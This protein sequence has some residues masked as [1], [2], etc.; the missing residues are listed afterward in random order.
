MAQ[1]RY[2]SGLDAEQRSKLEQKLLARQTGRCFICDDAIDLMLH[3]GQL[4][5]D[6]IDPLI[7]DGLDAENN[8][9]LTHASCN[10]SKG[11]ANLEI[12][13]RLAEFER[14]QDAAQEAGKRGANLG[15][16]LARYG[17]AKAVLRIRREAAHVEFSL[18]KVGDNSIRRVPVYHDTLSGMDSFFTALPLEYLHHDDRINPRSIGTNIRGLIEEFIR[19]RPQLHV[20]LAWWMPEEDGGGAVKVFDGQHK[21]AAQILLGTR[22]LPVRVFLEPDVNVLLLA[23]T[24]AGGRLRQVAFDSAVMRHLGSSL[25][26]ERVN[27]YKGM[28][29]LSEN[30]Y[31]FS[32]QD[33]VRFFRGERREMERYIIDAQRDAITHDPQNTLLEFVEWAGKGA[34]RPL[35]YTS[36][37]GSV[38]RVFLYKKALDTPIDLGMEEGTNPRQLERQQMVRLMSLFAEVFFVRHWDPELGGHKIESRMQDGEAIPE[39]QLRAWRI[40][41]EEVLA[42]VMRWM[43]LVIAN[44]FAYT[45]KVVHEDRQLHTRL[46]DELWDR[47]KNFLESLAR[48]PCWVD[49]NLST[50]VFGPKQNLDYWEKVFQTGR[51]PSGIQIL[52]APLDLNEMVRPKAAVAGRKP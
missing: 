20:G 2:L 34:A 39:G 38:F 50:T 44:Y 49:R 4:D 41:R 36:I 40:A 6:H 11:A 8:F 23:N 5:I 43:R 24:N 12:A 31:S 25:Y 28:R 42:N 46:P 9:A 52:T 32:E 51:S 17:G 47:L 45:G 29:G 14:L 1:S 21:A 13:R 15:D 7:E 48:L 10:R 37:D 26:V 35:S 22:E 3:K 18:P 19:K 33:L 30:D 16:V 27:R